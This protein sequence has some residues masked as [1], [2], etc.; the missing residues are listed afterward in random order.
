M[1]PHTASN[2]PANGPGFVVGWDGSRTA[3]HVWRF[4]HTGE[5]GRRGRGYLAIRRIMLTATSSTIAPTVAPMNPA[6]CPGW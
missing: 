2:V 3:V 5:P 4:H 1:L 6:V